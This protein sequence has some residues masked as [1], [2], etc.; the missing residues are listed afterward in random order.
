MARTRLFQKKFLTAGF[1]ILFNLLLISYQVPLGSKTTLLEKIFFQVTT[2]IIR[3]VNSL[4]NLVSSSWNNLKY[5]RQAAGKNI[6]LEKQVFFLTQENRLLQE[7][8]RLYISQ[9]ELENNLRMLGR[10]IIPARV[11]SFDTA[12]YYRSVII[13]KGSADGIVKN[14][15]VCDRFGNLIGRTAE[16]VALH[17]ARVLLVTS[18]ESGVGV[19]FSEE[20][21]PGVLSGDG[22]GNCLIKY[23]MLSSPGGKEGD[24]VQTSGFDKVFPPGLRVG[25]IIRVVSGEGVFKKI[26]VK[27]YFSLKDLELVAV[28]KDAPSILR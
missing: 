22:Q 4:I 9:S 27:P 16:P 2:P 25:R 1:L 15:P 14:L 21:W 17:E 19:V 6:E 8:L 7:K 5:L 12:N 20:R 28:I 26:I 11:I 18:E 23:I 24:E 3:G 13:N 10:D